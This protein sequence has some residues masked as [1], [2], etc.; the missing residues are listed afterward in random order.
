MPHHRLDLRLARQALLAACAV[1]MTVLPATAAAPP[2]SNAPFASG[3]DGLPIFV[4]QAAAIA[5]AAP[6]PHSTSPLP[7]EAPAALPV[8]TALQNTFGA[9]ENHRPPGAPPKAGNPF[10]AK[11]GSNGRMCYSCHEPNQGWT[12]TPPQ[13]R[14]RFQSSKGLAPLFAPVDGTT[15]STDDV[16]TLVART[17]AS[18]LLLSK[19]LIRVFETLPAAPTLQYSIV[20]IQDPYNCSTNPAT[21]LT[22]YGPDGT[23]AGVLSVYRRPLP[24]TNLAFLSSIMSDGR[25][26]SLAQQATDAVMVHEQAKTAPTAAEVAAIVAFESDI[27]TAQVLSDSAGALTKAPAHGGPVALSTQPFY[28]GINDPFGGNP[29]GAAFNPVVYSDYAAWAPGNSGSVGVSAA[30]GAARASIARGEAI[31]NQRRFTVGGTAATCS[32][33][34]DT[35]NA[36]S[37]SNF[38]LFA[39]GASEPGAPGLDLTGLPVFTLQ[40]NAGPLAGESFVTTDP[41]RAILTG[42][43]ADIATFAPPT[44]RNLAARPP[45]FHNGSA[46]SLDAVVSFYNARFTLGLSEQDH[47]DLVNFLAAL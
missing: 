4:E 37:N 2:P 3:P 16:S 1:M 30:V 34:H 31:F 40:C 17:K 46:P 29:T 10:F 23:S 14:A 13:I 5:A 6:L 27:F 35:P 45:Y 15:C 32:T 9:S 18:S 33:C 11:L 19:G 8:E 7:P 12:I 28:V 22:N 44:L 20:A 38:Q 43:C 26:A 24:V 39:I 41:G 42:Q 36:G 21:G 25:E 47:T